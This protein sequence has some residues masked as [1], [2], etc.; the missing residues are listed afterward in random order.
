MY[1]FDVWKKDFDG[2]KSSP[3]RCRLKLRPDRASPS[4]LLGYD[5]DEDEIEISR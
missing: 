2:R 3:R 1:D 5:E 4:P